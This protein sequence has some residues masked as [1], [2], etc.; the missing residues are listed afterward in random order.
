MLYVGIAAEESEKYIQQEIYCNRV[1][2][3]CH[4]SPS[5]ATLSG[6]AEAIEKLKETFTL[7]I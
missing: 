5:S 3:A 6:D 7:I 2:V 4:N 1:V